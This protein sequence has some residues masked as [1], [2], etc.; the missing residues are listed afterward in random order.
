[1][2]VEQSGVEFSM[3]VNCLDYPQEIYQS[4]LTT[5]SPSNRYYL[6]VLRFRENSLSSLDHPNQEVMSVR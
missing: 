6:V 2:N 4:L 3:I 1:L 5:L